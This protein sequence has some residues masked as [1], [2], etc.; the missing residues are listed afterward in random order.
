MKVMISTFG[1]QGDVQP[2][3]ALGQ[4][5]R[6]AGH[7]VAIC[8][9]ASYRPAIEALGLHHAPI[10]DTMLHLTRA[11]LEGGDQPLAVL[12]RM[13]P[14]LGAMV[15]EEWQGARAFTP[16]LMVYHAEDG[17]G[18]AVALLERYAA[19]EAVALIA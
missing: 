1:T 19:R 11:L 8:T 12:R 10:S 15:E 9:S 3:L 16:D 14:A 5:L 17:V 2:Y 6:A 4:R 13:G 7:T 18:N